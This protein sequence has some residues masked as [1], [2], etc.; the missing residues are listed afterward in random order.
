MLIAGPIN[1]GA[2]PPRRPPRPPAPLPQQDDW[3]P[4]VSTEV[5]PQ[6]ESQPQAATGCSQDGSQAVAQPQLATGAAIAQH[7]STGAAR[8]HEAAQLSADAQQDDG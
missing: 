5:A 8:E 3:Q 6:D 7:D 2:K 1:L 4:H